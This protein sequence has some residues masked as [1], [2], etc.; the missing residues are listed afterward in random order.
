MFLHSILIFNFF[1]LFFL[2]QQSWKSE[3]RDFWPSSENLIIIYTSCFTNSTALCEWNAIKSHPKKRLQLL[4]LHS[5][6]VNIRFVYGIMI[7]ESSNCFRQKVK[8]K[9]SFLLRSTRRQLSISMDDKLSN[10]KAWD[11]F[12]IHLVNGVKRLTQRP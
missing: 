2:M 11:H 5:V 6:K 9:R 10:V 1:H 8:K 12:P 7:R 4:I 3:K